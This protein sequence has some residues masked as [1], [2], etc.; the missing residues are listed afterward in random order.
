MGAA[1]STAG[2]KPSDESTVSLFNAHQGMRLFQHKVT[3]EIIVLFNE[4]MVSYL[5][6]KARGQYDE[7]VLSSQQSDYFRQLKVKV[8][9]PK[10]NLG[11]VEASPPP[12]VASPS[13]APDNT[14]DAELR[15][16]PSFV[17]PVVNG[18]AEHD[19]VRKRMS[20]LRQ[21]AAIDKTAYNLAEPKIS[22]RSGAGD[23][24]GK[25][26]RK[27]VPQPYFPPSV[28]Q[29][30]SRLVAEWHSLSQ[31]ISEAKT[32]PDAAAGAKDFPSK[33]LSE[34]SEDSAGAGG[35]KSPVGAGFARCKLCHETFFGRSAAEALED[36]QPMCITHVELRRQLEEVDERM[37]TVSQF[38]N[39]LTTALSHSV[40]LQS[41]S[42]F[43]GTSVEEMREIM[44][45][46][47]FAAADE[48]D[49]ADALM[50]RVKKLQRRA[51]SVQ[52]CTANEK[53][54]CKLRETFE[55]DLNSLKHKITVL[56]DD[57]R[58][59]SGVVQRHRSAV[60]ALSDALTLLKD[61]QAILRRH[62]P[63]RHGPKDYKFLRLL[64]KGGFASVYLARRSD[65]RKLC[66]IKVLNKETIRKAGCQTQVLR[67]RISLTIASRFPD[68]FVRFLSSFQSQ[69]HLFIV[70]EYVQGGDCM[71]LLN[72][73]K[74]F[75]EVVAQHFIAQVCLGVRHLHRNGVVHR[76][77]KPDNVLITSL[78]H[79]KLGDFGLIVSYT[80]DPRLGQLPAVD[81]DAAITQAPV[82]APTVVPAAPVSTLGQRRFSNNADGGLFAM[83][84]VGLE[85]TRSSAAAYLASEQRTWLEEESSG[86]GSQGLGGAAHSNREGMF[87]DLLSAGSGSSLFLPPSF[88]ERNP[89]PAAA[90]DPRRKLRS[91]VGNYNYSCPELVL[92]KGYDHGV[93]WWAVAVLLFHFLAGSTPFESD[94]PEQT[95]DN[96]VTCAVNW[97]ALP[98]Q[99]SEDC[100]HF[101]AAIITEPDADKR[102]G[103]SSSD[104]VLGHRFFR[105]VD[106]NTLYQGY[107][108]IYPQLKPSG[109]SKHGKGYSQSQSTSFTASFAQDDEI[110]L[111]ASV[112][113]ETEA[114]DLAQLMAYEHSA[115]EDKAT[116]TAVSS[117]FEDFD[118]LYA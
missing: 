8:T 105:D 116:P 101:I 49:K 17:P 89:H 112:A 87:Q 76:D 29:Q 99:V 108:P 58:S 107:G 28:Y 70:M 88:D 41:L 15:P 42:S 114:S 40:F 90:A 9:V 30:D 117:D 73:L 35:E 18:A 61:K 68:F 97:S 81:P 54:I 50:H 14:P 36:H 118:C 78:G 48:M 84:G 3:G 69:H 4:D 31:S 80:R 75:P 67:E 27:F 66:A 55:A 2:A 109:H 92:H 59:S 52:V 60:G 34:K 33:R 26:Y 98:G 110:E 100:R 115:Q 13:P 106:L 64:G 12:T 22:P 94:S 47:I 53:V 39:S 37:K 23:K 25:G 46:A 1:A 86:L 79:A 38:I 57:P 16:M 111:F 91:L 71:T 102:L 82:P 72:S 65:N 96:I 44:S 32:S 93:D 45:S 43:T 5:G 63:M 21:A 83:S 77:I 104:Q 11:P 6:E 19:I 10:S 56:T 20:T 24:G 95:M 62:S 51:L 103:F 85:R 113:S 74:R 7:A